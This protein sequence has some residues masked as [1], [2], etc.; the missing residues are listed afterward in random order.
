MTDQR[1]DNHLERVDLLRAAAWGAF[2][3]GD[4]SGAAESFAALLEAG[5]L[6][7]IDLAAAVEIAIDG[8]GVAAGVALMTRVLDDWL[9][10]REPRALLRLARQAF[11]IASH[12]SVQPGTRANAGLRILELLA[13][14]N[15][16][17]E[18]TSAITSGELDGIETAQIDPLGLL[19]ALEQLAFA[20]PE[21]GLPDRAVSRLESTGHAYAHDPVV[22]RTA[23][24]LLHALGRP[25]LAYG[26]ERAKRDARPKTTAAVRD[27]GEMD[28]LSI[29][30]LRV[31]I[32]G[33]HPALRSVI[34]KDLG[35]AKITDVREVPSR[36]EASRIGRDV[37]ATIAG[38]DV[39]VLLVRQLAHSTSD[40]V[41]KAAARQ[42]VPVAVSDS[43]GVSGVRRALER[44]ARERRSTEG[45][46]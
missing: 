29:A 16:L 2:D 17:N 43:A 30:G 19:D 24:R 7:E 46:G 32:A 39:V 42:G 31:A 22:A 45:P 15:D 36:Q 9:P 11:A 44:F 35:R 23:E 25:E 13:V 26:V 10:D 21:T 8:E 6:T 28:D 18:W 20:P 12:P 41:R 3:D 33:G 4:F 34:R 27:T 5:E 1:Q 40:Q 14:A 38:A 37:Q